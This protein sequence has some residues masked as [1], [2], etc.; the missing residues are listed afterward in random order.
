MRLMTGAPIPTGCSTVVKQE[1]VERHGND[2]VLMEDAA[3]GANIRRVGEDVAQG[4]LLVR[5]GTFLDSRHTALLA[6]CGVR[7]LDVVRKIRVAVAAFGNELRK[8]GSSLRAGQIYDANSAMARAFLTRPSTRFVECVRATDDRAWASEL[9]RD[10]SAD[11][12]LI[13][14]SGGMAGGDADHTRPSLEQAGGQWHLTSIRMKPGKPAGVGKIGA[15][16]IIS[17]PGNPFAALAA[18]ALLGTPVLA[19][20][21]GGINQ[22]RWQPARSDFRLVRTPGRTEFFPAKVSGYDQGGASLL[23]RMGKGGSARLKPL[24][25]ADGLGRIEA[26]VAEVGPGASLQFVPFSGIFG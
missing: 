16:V 17:L 12:D 24:V 7:K 14:T 23:E 20:L 10:L 13:V 4:D 9:L 25:E 19:C 8:P 18:L 22:L 3:L 5:A 15:T 6:A 11:T 21:A 26:E 2:I 1:R